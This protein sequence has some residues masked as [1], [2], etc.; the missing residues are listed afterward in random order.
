MTSYFLML[1][2]AVLTS[3]V[4]FALVYRR[5]YLVGDRTAE[6]V[7]PAISPLGAMGVHELFSRAAEQCLRA[8]LTPDQFRR[9][10][11]HRI[12]LALEYMRRISHNSLVLQQWALYEMARARATVDRRQSHLSLDLIAASV[13]CRILSSMFSTRLNWWR[14]RLALL[15]FDSPGFDA[16]IKFGSTDIVDFYRTMRSAAADL[17]RGCEG[18]HR[19]TLAELL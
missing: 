3:S 14:V 11:R 6:Q 19:N 10:Q 5:I 4:L 2:P 9:A 18:I 13:K 1:A 7:I 16:L 15:P 17:A 8:N 12:L